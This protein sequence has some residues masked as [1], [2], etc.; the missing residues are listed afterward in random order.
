MT[1]HLGASAS[2]VLRK[3]A[4]SRVGAGRE[5]VIGPA[6]GLVSEDDD[7]I[8]LGPHFD[9]DSA[10]KVLEALGLV[11]YEDFFGITHEGGQA[12]EWCQT[13]LALR[14]RDG[15]ALADPK[16]YLRDV[17]YEIRRRAEEVAATADGSDFAQGRRLAYY[18]V[19]DHLKNQAEVFEL[20]LEAICLDFDPTSILNR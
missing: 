17:I 8:V 18:E 19:L 13:L 16:L 15:L 12:P 9:P 1:V 2:V 10:D 7:L 5:Q 14:D 4:L 6:G 3:S 11:W 20:P